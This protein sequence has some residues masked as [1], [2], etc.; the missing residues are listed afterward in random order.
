MIGI[1]ADTEPKT[2]KRTANAPVPSARAGGLPRAGTARV[3]GLGVAFNGIHDS[4]PSRRRRRR[5]T[6]LRL[7]AST[8]PRPSRKH[9]AD[10]SVAAR[11][12][13]RSPPWRP[14]SSRSGPVLQGA[15]DRHNGEPRGGDTRS[16]RG[17]GR[18]QDRRWAWLRPA[19]M[20]NAHC[21]QLVVACDL[22]RNAPGRHSSRGRPE[23]PS[24][25]AAFGWR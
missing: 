7:A 1:I 23:T 14:P 17:A 15:Q 11:G 19:R 5:R 18:S 9:A 4:P 3:A 10:A 8:R 25:V 6:S 21:E 12:S 16:R 22:E 20:Q 24:P 13:S 2:E